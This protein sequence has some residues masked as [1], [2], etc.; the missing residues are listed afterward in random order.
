MI[1]EDD[2][3]PFEFIAGNKGSGFGKVNFEDFRNHQDHEIRMGWLYPGSEHDRFMLLNEEE[4]IIDIGKF[5]N[6]RLG[7]TWNF[8][9]SK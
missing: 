3:N 2:H 9:Y 7:K 4:V 6:A 5:S 8:F 1:M